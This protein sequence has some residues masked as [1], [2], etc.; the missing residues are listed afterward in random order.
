MGGCPC[1]QL[2]AAA[3][4]SP[5]PAHAPNAAAADKGKVISKPPGK[6]SG[7][8]A[9]AESQDHIPTAP[10]GLC[11]YQ[12][13]IAA[14]DPT[15]WM[16]NRDVFGWMKDRQRATEY[17]KQSKVLRERLAQR[18]EE[19][20]LEARA[21]R[22]R[23]PGP[24]GFPG[25]EEMDDFAHI[26]GGRIEVAELDDPSVPVTTHGVGRFLFRIL[27]QNI[28]D[29]KGASCGHWVLAKQLPAAAAPPAPN[30]FRLRSKQASAAYPAPGIS[31][32]EDDGS[33]A[34]LCDGSDPETANPR[35]KRV[36]DPEAAFEARAAAAAALNV[37][38]EA[39]A[40]LW[41]PGEDSE[42]ENA[43]DM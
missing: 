1:K 3:A 29:I 27:Y 39:S 40:P 43:E 28:S 13:A 20:G 10:D 41:D 16:V 5:P 42:A 18:L 23:L 17:A 37:D 7:G 33:V 2:P 11:M 15:A 34:E 36:M 12:V 25:N 14:E 22:L 30:R 19:R 38:Q 6:L 24:A 26:L 35:P 9:D 4:A 21:F 8:A 32:P 31:H